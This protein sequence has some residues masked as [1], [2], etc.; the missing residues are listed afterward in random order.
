MAKTV[1]AQV[2]HIDRF[3]ASIRDELPPD[4]DLTVEGVVDRITGLGKRLKRM[5][6]ETLAEHDLTWGEWKV[7]G[8]LI[9]Q[10]PPYRSSPGRLAEHLELSSGAMTNRLD[11]LEEAGLIRRLP[12]PSDRRGIHVELTAAGRKLYKQST[13]TAAA[14]EALLAS[15]LN[16]REREQL[17]GLLRRLMIAFEKLYPPQR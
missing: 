3:L 1:E 11:Q 13:A 7:L 16:E 12:D 10:G 5:M 2:D 6:E 4:I 14:R 15:A 9:H 8:F 17:N